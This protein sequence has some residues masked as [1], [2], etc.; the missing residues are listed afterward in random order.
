[1]KTRNVAHTIAAVIVLCHGV[2]YGAAI[3][4]ALAADIRHC[5]QDVRFLIKEVEVGL[6]ADV[7]TLTRLLK[8]GMSYS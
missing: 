5:S 4:L 6:T 3:D 8:V 2:V 1:M 7:G